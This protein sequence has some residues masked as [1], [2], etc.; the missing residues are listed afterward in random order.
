MNRRTAFLR[1][2]ALICATRPCFDAAAQTQTDELQQALRRGGCALVLRHAQTES[3]IGDPPGFRLDACSTQRNL[4]AEGKGQAQ[5][6][7]V[8][9]KARGLEPQRVYSS[10]WC[11]CKDTADLAFGRHILL[12][13]LNST[14]EARSSQEAQT[15]GLKIRLAN[16]TP[17]NFEVWITHQVNISALTGRGPSMASGFIV[18]RRGEVVAPFSVT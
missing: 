1:S 15:A 3:G 2:L 13:E 7:G 18:G 11:R 8:W 9:F 4:S 6:I 17:G 16:L 14:F 12:P 5:K 10:A